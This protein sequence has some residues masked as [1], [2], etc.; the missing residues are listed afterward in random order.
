MEH[1]CLVFRQ[2]TSE[3]ALGRTG[4]FGYLETPG[5]VLVLF[6]LFEETG[7]GGGGLGEGWGGR[8]RGGVW[9]AKSLTS[10]KLNSGSGR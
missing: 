9:G 10:R 6:F 5:L 1:G 3:I 7:G 2:E 8:E 4:K